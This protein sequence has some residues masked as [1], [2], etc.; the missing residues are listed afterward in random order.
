MDTCLEMNPDRAR[1]DDYVKGKSDAGGQ[2]GDQAVVATLAQQ[3]LDIIA[4]EPLYYTDIAERFSSY[5]FRTVAQAL[6]HFVLPFEPAPIVVTRRFGDLID[7]R[8][9][10]LGLATCCQTRNFSAWRL[11]GSIGRI[12]SKLD[13]VA[14]F[15]GTPASGAKGRRMPTIRDVAQAAR[16]ST[17][18][19][20]RRKI[21][22]SSS[23]ATLSSSTIKI[24]LMRL[25][26]RSAA[27]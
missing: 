24:W 13:E 25:Y 8:N 27:G 21:S 15:S 19:P 11:L 12:L 6:G 5:D 23:R 14:H 17:V 16:A 7:Y 10:L 20:S 26:A 2:A 22:S 4:K 18:C 1:I 3:I 9:R